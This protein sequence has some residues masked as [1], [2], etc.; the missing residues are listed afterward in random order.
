M[1]ALVGRQ[2]VKRKFPIP[3][4]SVV[5]IRLENGSW[6]MLYNDIEDVRYS[7]DVSLSENEGETWPYKRHLDNDKTRN[8]SFSYPS[9][10]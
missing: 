4:M 5:T 10:L 3:G 2:Q 9:I 7:L 8:S 6:I 1:M